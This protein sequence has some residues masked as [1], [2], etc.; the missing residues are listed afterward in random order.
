LGLHLVKHY[1]DSIHYDH[2][3]G[4]STITVTKRLRA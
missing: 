2:R 1:A 4:N 3:E